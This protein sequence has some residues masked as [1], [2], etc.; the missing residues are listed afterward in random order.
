MIRKIYCDAKD[1]IHN[2]GGPCAS[3]VVDI[4]SYVGPED[5]HAYCDSYATENA[6]T[7][8]SSNEMTSASTTAQTLANNSGLTQE[9]TNELSDIVGCT[10]TECVYN[11]NTMCAATSVYVQSPEGMGDT[12]S[13]CGTYQKEND[14]N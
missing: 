10:A 7:A 3:G 4:K 6:F 12:M 9:N 8:N 2:A 5:T 14:Y 13:L 11:V 1:C